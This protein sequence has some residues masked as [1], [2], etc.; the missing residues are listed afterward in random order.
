LIL[1]LLSDREGSS[2]LFDSDVSCQPLG[3]H[4]VSVVAHIL[5]KNRACSFKSKHEL[6][7][8]A[9]FDSFLGRSSFC[10]VEYSVVVFV[11]LLS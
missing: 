11:K 9:F 7:V 3:V 10:L 4:F 1:H 6:V 2:L 5:E 8:E